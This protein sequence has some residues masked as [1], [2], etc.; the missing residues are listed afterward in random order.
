MYGLFSFCTIGLTILLFTKGVERLLSVLHIFVQSEKVT[1][2]LFGI[3]SLKTLGGV[4]NAWGGGEGVLFR[5]RGSQSRPGVVIVPG[6]FLFS[7]VLS[8]G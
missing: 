2:R 4:L 3:G 8:L 7:G 1:F 6:E 5:I